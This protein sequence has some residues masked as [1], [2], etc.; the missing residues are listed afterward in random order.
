M[1]CTICGKDFKNLLKHLRKNKICESEHDVDKIVSDRR[2]KR[3][4][5]MKNTSRKHYK[6]YRVT[7]QEYYDKNKNSIRKKQVKYKSENEFRIKTKDAQ[8]KKVKRLIIKDKKAEYYSKNR[9]LIAQKKRFY[10][11]F[12]K[13]DAWK[14]I[15]SHQDHLFYHTLGLCQ[16]ESIKSMNHSIEYYNG[17]CILCNAPHGIKIIG[18]NRQV[19]MNCMKAQCVLCSSEVSPDPEF[20]C[21]H[22]SPDSGSLLSFCQ[23]TVPSILTIAFPDPRLLQIQKIRKTVKFVLKSRK[24]IRSTIFWTDGKKI[25]PWRRWL[26]I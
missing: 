24:I 13:E 8:Y 14:Y 22:Y 12:K 9:G 10:R 19:C 2:L 17:I 15:T 1:K 26:A 25:H 21:L 7:K 4:E 23:D 6:K 20:G 3:L 11:H 16:A 5:D 18:V